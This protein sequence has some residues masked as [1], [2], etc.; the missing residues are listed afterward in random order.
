MK[1]KEQKRGKKQK[2]K[3][4]NR[5]GVIFKPIVEAIRKKQEIKKPKI[6]EPEYFSWAMEAD[7]DER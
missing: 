2:E 4:K 6:R 5:F 1:K 3:P 7:I